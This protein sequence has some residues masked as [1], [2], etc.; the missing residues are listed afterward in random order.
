[1]LHIRGVKTALADRYVPIPNVL[2]DLIPFDDRYYLVSSISGISPAKKHHRVKLWNRFK[3]LLQEKID[4][5][6]DLTPYCLRHTYCTDLR[7]AGIP[8]STA[9]DLMGHST[10]KL[11][12]DIYT[13]QTFRNIKK[14]AERLN[15]HLLH[16]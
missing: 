3:S 8:L 2:L 12:A 9:K 5:K 10:V 14:S 16:K 7:D 6:D 4:V 11:T 1:M 13:H 15:A